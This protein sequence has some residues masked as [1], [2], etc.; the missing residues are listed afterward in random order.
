MIKFNNKYCSNK[1][2][3]LKARHVIFDAISDAISRTK[4]ALPYP[5][6]F[7]RGASRGLE[8]KLTYYLKT[9]LFAIPTNWM[10]FRRSIT[11]LKTSAG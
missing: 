3:R 2:E 9:P 4:C 8:R 1:R 5:A 7:F 11:R 6:G 10:V